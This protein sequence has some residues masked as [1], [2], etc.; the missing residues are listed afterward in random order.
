MALFSRDAT[1]FRPGEIIADR[2]RITGIL[3]RGGFGA[4]YAGEHTGTEQAVAIKMLASEG[5][6]DGEAGERFYREARITAKLTHPN[7]VRVFDV[8]Q[9]ENGPLYLVMEMLRGPTLEQILHSLKDKRLGMSETQAIALILPV[10]SSLAEAHAAGL[11]HRDLKPAN[12][13]LHDVPGSEPV[14]KVLDFGCSHTQDSELTAQGAVLGTPGYMSPEQCR[15]DE[16]GPSSDLYSVAV[17]LYRCVAGQLPFDTNQPL[18]LIYK[19]AHEPVPDPRTRAVDRHVSNAMAEVLLRGLA[20]TADS[21]FPSAREMGRSL[22]RIRSNVNNAPVNLD[23]EGRTHIAG[24]PIDGGKQL[25]SLML[26]A[27][28]GYQPP[29]SRRSDNVHHDPTDAGDGFQARTRAY[30]GTIAAPPPPA[31]PAPSAAIEDDGPATVMRAAAAPWHDAAQEAPTPQTQLG[32]AAPAK[33]KTP[34]IAA[35][36][37]ILLLLV[38]AAVMFGGDKPTTAAQTAVAATP[39]PAPAKKRPTRAAVPTE[40]ELKRQSE[41]RMAGR[42][43]DL[44]RATTDLDARVRHLIAAVKLAPDNEKYTAELKAAQGLAQMQAQLEKRAETAAKAARAQHR[45]ARPRKQPAAAPPPPPPATKPAG[46]RIPAAILE[47]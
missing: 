26:L 37:A 3:G 6:S 19:H 1:S 45:R 27:V 4:V 15:G 39:A 34:L 29:E 8:G 10:L 36:L 32:E 2:Y 25:V 7:T 5:G 23:G 46:N 33:S 31:A 41:Q 16:V 11:V 9:V 20:K 12:L 43:V 22:E 47:E 14:M 13:M 21:R 17:I 35:A 18:Q 38:G 28:D 24:S 44:A 42:H 30:A 40:E